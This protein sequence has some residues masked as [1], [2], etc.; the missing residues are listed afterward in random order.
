MGS[1]HL[2]RDP[3]IPTWDP[4]WDDFFISGLNVP[5]DLITV[6]PVVFLH[7]VVLFCLF[8]FVVVDQ[9]YYLLLHFY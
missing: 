3:A 4:G 1:H 7:E 9:V 6:F 5:F 8:A 2:R